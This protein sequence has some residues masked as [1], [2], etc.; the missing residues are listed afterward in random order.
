M[1]F[2]KEALKLKRKLEKIQPKKPEQFNDEM[3]ER[4]SFPDED[5]V[6]EKLSEYFGFLRN[7][8]ILPENERR[9]IIEIVREEWAV[10]ALLKLPINPEK[11]INI[12]NGGNLLERLSTKIGFSLRILA[13]PVDSCLLCKEFLAVS[14][15]PTQIAV[16]TLTGPKI[17][18]KYMLRCQSC[19]LV[20]TSKF[21]KR[22]ESKRQTIYYHPDKYGNMTNGFMFYKQD[23]DYVKASNEV[24]LEKAFLESC[25]SNLMH[26]FISM[27]STAEAYNE[28]FR[29]K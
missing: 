6:E 16:H 4:V 28:T 14:S 22:N 26:G 15:K 17:Y 5:C 8:P 9:K 20:K 23:I 18:T 19:R 1:E 3:L 7:L 2:N 25:L 21:D 11:L 29:N 10:D 27:E 12:R 24:F 13:P